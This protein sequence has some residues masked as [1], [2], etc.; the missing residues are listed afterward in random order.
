MHARRRSVP[1]QIREWLLDP[2]AHGELG[3]GARGISPDRV[4]CEVPP[5]TSLI[6]RPKLDSNATC[7]AYKEIL[8]NVSTQFETTLEFDPAAMKIVN[9]PDADRL[10]SGD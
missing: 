3:T 7:S 2:V 4:F 1:Q 5:R 9:N 8:G 10:P 6:R